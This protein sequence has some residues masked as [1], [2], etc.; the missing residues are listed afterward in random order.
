MEANLSKPSPGTAIKL[1]LGNGTA[2]EPP[3]RGTSFNISTERLSTDR[4]HARQAVGI[5][6][7]TGYS[8][9]WHP[10]KTLCGHQRHAQKL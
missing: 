3:V 2:C 9:G 4:H 6:S 1:Q 7:H 5:Q 10:S 8:L